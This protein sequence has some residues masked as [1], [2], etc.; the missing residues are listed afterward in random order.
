MSLCAVL[1]STF[2]HFSGMYLLFLSYKQLEGRWLGWSSSVIHDSV[3]I[4]SINSPDGN[5]QARETFSV[6]P[7]IGSLPFKW[8]AW[9]KVWKSSVSEMNLQLQLLIGIIS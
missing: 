4:S 1:G 7:A 9:I 3:D 6:G 8:G 5:D 2:L